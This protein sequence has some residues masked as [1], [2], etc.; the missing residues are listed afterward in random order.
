MICGERNGCG[1]T[2]NKP[3]EKPLAS[4]IDFY[5]STTIEGYILVAESRT[6]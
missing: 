6:Q 1:V 3:S 5:I 2:R 4:E